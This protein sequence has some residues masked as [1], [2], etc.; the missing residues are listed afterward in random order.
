MIKQSTVSMVLS[1]V[2]HH[3]VKQVYWNVNR[4]NRRAEGAGA[5]A[6]LFR[7][8]RGGGSPVRGGAPG[9]LKRTI[10]CAAPIAG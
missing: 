10:E 8:G 5:D 6:I 9:S 1:L 7:I 4:N 3:M 2:I